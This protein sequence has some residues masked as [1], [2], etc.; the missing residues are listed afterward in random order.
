M[1]VSRRRRP[2]QKCPTATTEIYRRPNWWR[3]DY[4]MYLYISTYTQTERPTDR[5][6]TEPH[7]FGFRWDNLSEHFTGTSHPDGGT[8]LP[9]CSS[10]CSVCAFCTHTHR[11]T[12]QHQPVPSESLMKD[13]FSFYSL[14]T[15]G[16]QFGTQVRP[17]TRT[18]LAKRAMGL[19]GGV[20]VCA[21]TCN[22]PPLYA[23]YTICCVLRRVCV[24]RALNGV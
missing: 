8:M 11:H 21:C 3:P 4:A 17:P 1:W 2:V 6:A 19:S 13:N 10:H 12:H 5:E 7:D 23:Y 18:K 9:P 15:C 20:C 24:S 22:I 14:W 16:F